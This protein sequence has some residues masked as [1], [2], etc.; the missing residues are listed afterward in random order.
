MPSSRPA[1]SIA[2]R[3]PECCIVVA[4][5]DA[6][7]LGEA[8]QVVPH[9]LEGLVGV[10]V[11]IL[12]VEDLDPRTLQRLLEGFDADSV[13][14]GRDAAHHHDL[15]AV[16]EFRLEIFRGDHAGLRV[17][18]TD[19]K[20]FD[21]FARAERQVDAFQHPVRAI[22]MCNSIQP[23]RVRLHVKSSTATETPIHEI[24]Q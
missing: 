3:A 1:C 9:D 4:G 13:D 14:G 22:G 19:I 20:V 15:A 6:V 12:H 21:A 18:A 16:S 10:P 23:K 7:N 2:A 8:G 24:L 11:G 17:V 5:P